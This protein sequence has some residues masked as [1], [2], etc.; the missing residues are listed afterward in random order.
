MT[1]DLTRYWYSKSFHLV[2]LLFLPFS[3]FFAFCAGTRRWLY[4]TGV[5]KIRRFTVPVMVVGNITV[6]GT[7]KTPFVIW[8]AHFL[9]SQG[10]RP[11]IVSR[12]AGGKKH[13][14]PY[15]V[16]SDDSAEEVG[17]EAILLS[18]HTGCPVVI[19][20]D[21]VAVVQDLLQHSPCNIVIS[22]DG[23][24]HYR[25][26]RDVEIA[27]VDGVRRFGNH[28][29]LPAG[30]LREPISR[31]QK[32][33]LVVVNGG[34]QDDEFTMTLEPLQWVAL[35]NHQKKMNL[36]DFP[37]KKVHAIAGIGHPERFFVLLKNAGFEIIAHFF[38]DHHLY[39]AHELDFNDNLPI[40]M[41]EKD[42]VKC[43]SFADERYWYLPIIAKMN[44]NLE[45]K[46]LQ[47]LTAKEVCND[48]EDNVAKRIC[49]I[50]H[51]AQLGNIRK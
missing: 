11:G 46:L 51:S 43:E 42:A 44:N 8:L 30:P 3:W 50:T 17:D 40:V 1:V 2:T 45:Q 35:K 22:D 12:G 20:T 18:Q 5:I 37:T 32:V 36:A 38:P 10:Y 39:Q 34:D 31:L 23:L 33:D 26:G 48:I 21:R 25:L 7:G 28:C 15:W 14:E 47:K 4:H 16:K 13:V 29:L 6:G 41:T 27:I 9:Q 24:Q 49:P 19:G